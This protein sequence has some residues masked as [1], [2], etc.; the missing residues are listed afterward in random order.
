[1]EYLPFGETLVDEHLNSYNTPFKFNG[2]E[3]DEET[4]N[5]YYGARYYNPK[6]SN[7]LSVDP[8][9]EQTMD[10]YG[11]CY[12]NPINLVDPSGMSAENIDDII[13]KGK[14]NSSITILS[15]IDFTFHTDIDYGGNHTTELSYENM[16]IGHGVTGGVEAGLV[17]GGYASGELGSFMMLGGDYKNYWYD[18]ASGQYGASVGI[19]GDAGFSGGRFYSLGLNLTGNKNPSSIEGKFETTTVS[20]ST[21]LLGAFVSEAT[22]AALGIDLDMKFSIG[23]SIDIELARSK[24]WLVLSWGVSLNGGVGINLQ[25]TEIAADAGTT[26]LPTITPIQKTDNRSSIDKATNQFFGWKRFLGH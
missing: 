19:Q 23:P 8:L 26:L 1:M 17:I 15:D 10:P 22:S 9:A 6:W 21:D 16:M 20:F 4:G 11:Y 25:D 5:Y 12:N 2:K 3:L 7:W 14:N 24:D 13:I 18:Y